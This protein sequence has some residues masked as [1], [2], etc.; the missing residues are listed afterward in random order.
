MSLTQQQEGFELAAQ[1][2]LN[3]SAASADSIDVSIEQD[4]YQET[5]PPCSGRGQKGALVKHDAGLLGQLRQL[6]QKLQ[7]KMAR[8]LASATRHV[9]AKVDR[10]LDEKVRELERRMTQVVMMVVRER[11]E[12]VKKEVVM[13]RGAKGGQWST[14]KRSPVASTKCSTN[15]NL[16]MEMRNAD[17]SMNHEN[18]SIVNEYD[19]MNGDL[20]LPYPN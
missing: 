2:P 19:H 8:D 4:M 6:D 9:E 10:K 18:D 1:G 7:E 11:V 20:M 13:A 16:S 12:E 15:K 3:L 14:V 5:E 17:E